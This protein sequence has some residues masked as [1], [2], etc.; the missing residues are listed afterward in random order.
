MI[1]NQPLRPMSELLA[2]QQQ[3]QQSQQQYQ[4]PVQQV[5]QQ[6]YPQPVQQQPVQQQA[7][8]GGTNVFQ[9]SDASQLQALQ[10]NGKV[11]VVIEDRTRG[12]FVISGDQINIASIDQQTGGIG[13]GNEL[14]LFDT[15][16]DG[17]LIENE[18]KVAATAAAP[19]KVSSFENIASATLGGT[20]FGSIVLG[21]TGLGAKLG[22]AIGGKL[23]GVSGYAI[24][25]G[26]GAVL[27]IAGGLIKDHYDNKKVLNDSKVLS[28]TP[29]G[30]RPE[31][32]WDTNRFIKA[33]Y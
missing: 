9:V 10:N 27:G 19:K 29:T 31:T 26:V 17:F 33:I 4:Q 22:N 15:N 7:A 18:L 3:M 5:P 6:Q 13:V 30:Y 24:G 11:E 21:K 23:A 32:Q 20:A 14:R 8:P 12:Y 1:N 28:A 25:A 16:N 2:Q